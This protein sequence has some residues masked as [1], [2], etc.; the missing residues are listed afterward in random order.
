MKNQSG[1][2]K[3]VITEE[4]IFDQNKLSKYLNNHFNFIYNLLFFCDHTCYCVCMVSWT[5]AAHYVT[6]VPRYQV[7]PR[8]TSMELANAVQIVGQWKPKT[9]CWLDC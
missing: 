8:C 6:S 5:S 2:N 7:D 1:E 4:F 3:L 9:V